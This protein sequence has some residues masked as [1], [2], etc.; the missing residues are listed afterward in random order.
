MPKTRSNIC[1]I[2]MLASR[3]VQGLH[4]KVSIKPLLDKPVLLEEVLG[5]AAAMA[6][7]GAA[8]AFTSASGGAPATFCGSCDRG[9]LCPEV[10]CGG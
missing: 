1:A 10:D 7:V 4:L 9:I 6:M 2:H 8:S 3:T 5:G